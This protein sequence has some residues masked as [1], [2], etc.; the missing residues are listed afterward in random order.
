MSPRVPRRSRSGPE[1]SLHVQVRGGGLEGSVC[2][3][4]PTSTTTPHPG[5]RHKILQEERPTGGFKLNDDNKVEQ[6]LT[7]WGQE[8]R[9]RRG[10]GLVGLKR[11]STY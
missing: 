10:T 1:Q 3:S 9:Q 11:H 7:P 4:T 6:S 8:S 5:R 2:V